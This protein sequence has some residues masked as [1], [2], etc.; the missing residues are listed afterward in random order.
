MKDCR[1]CDEAIRSGINSRRSRI[2]HKL[3]GRALEDVHSFGFHKR[4]HLEKLP[5]LWW[6]K[7]KKKISSIR[8][9]FIELPKGE[10]SSGTGLLI[11]SLFAT[12]KLLN[13][14]GSM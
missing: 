14:T 3:D 7:R 8:S 13:L 11:H 6:E 12:S 9:N 1:L 5:P 10:T 2:L 4:R